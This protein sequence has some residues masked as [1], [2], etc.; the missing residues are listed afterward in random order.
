MQPSTNMLACMSNDTKTNFYKYDPLKYGDNENT[1]IVDN[2]IKN[3]TKKQ[4]VKEQ[5]QKKAL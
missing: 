5:L 1:R 3:K 2:V 4:F